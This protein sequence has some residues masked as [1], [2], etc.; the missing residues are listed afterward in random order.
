MLVGW[1]EGQKDRERERE[2]EN[3]ETTNGEEKGLYLGRAK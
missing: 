3:T 1:W 2:R